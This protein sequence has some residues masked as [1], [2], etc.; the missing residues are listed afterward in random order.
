[1]NPQ[2]EWT[3]GGLAVT[4]TDLARWARLLYEGKVIDPSLMDDL[5]DGVPAK[6]GPETKYGLG[7]IIRPTQFGT[8]YGHSG[9]MPG[10]QTDVMYFPQLK[11]SI[12]VQVNSSAPR[13]TGRP[14][15]AF[16]TDF[17]DVVYRSSHGRLESAH[18]EHVDRHR[19]NSDR[20]ASR[21]WPKESIPSSLFR[22]VHRPEP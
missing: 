3:G 5:L 8:T 6:L 14:L 1:V 16:L 17:A 7:V 20:G 22:S 2:F 4:A 12:A 21:S 15:R 19:H 10:Y 18:R 9:F 11:S 13:S